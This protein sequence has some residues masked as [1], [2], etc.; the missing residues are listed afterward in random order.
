MRAAA[1]VV[2]LRCPAL[3]LIAALA[4]EFERFSSEIA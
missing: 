1:G 4:L 3:R 2:F